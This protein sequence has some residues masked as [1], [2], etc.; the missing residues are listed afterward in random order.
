[1]YTCA[2]FMIYL[3]GN[4][5]MYT[6]AAFMTMTMTM[7]YILGLVLPTKDDDQNFSF[8]IRNPNFL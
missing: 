3:R 2:A 8:V 5:N 7:I 1:M 6:C 4:N